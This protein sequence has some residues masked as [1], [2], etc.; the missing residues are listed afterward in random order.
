MKAMGVL[1]IADCQLPIEFIVDCRLSISNC[2]F[3]LSSDGSH[4]LRLSIATYKSPIGNR[5]LEI[6]N[7]FYQRSTALPH[8]KPPPNDDIR[9]TSPSLTRPV[10]THSSRP[11]GI[12]ADEVFPCMAMF[13]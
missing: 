6:G 3:V 13:E 4:W 9:M 12:D 11:I 8:V 1:P 2:R 7:T 5:Q 10:S